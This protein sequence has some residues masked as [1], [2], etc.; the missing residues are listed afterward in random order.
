[1]P[2]GASR[3]SPIAA[4]RRS[5]LIHLQRGDEG[6]LRDVD[7]AELA[8]LLLALF[9]LVEELALAGDVAAVAFGGD[10]F[11]ER[12][13]GLAGDDLAADGRLDRDLEEM[14]RDQLFQLLAH[15]PPARF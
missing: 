4:N 1:M 9:L 3:C 10:V 15:H 2:A 6:F 12:R 7:L 14:A 5:I 8:H 11:P 13:D